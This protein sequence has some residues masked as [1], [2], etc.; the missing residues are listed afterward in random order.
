MHGATCVFRSNLTPFSL[1][2]PASDEEPGGS[3][4]EAAAP[5]KKQK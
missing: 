2:Q 3:G 4:D 1:G 5:P